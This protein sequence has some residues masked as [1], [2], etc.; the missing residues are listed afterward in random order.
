MALY[1]YIVCNIC[2]VVRDLLNKKSAAR[3]DFR[4]DVTGQDLRDV[5]NSLLWKTIKSTDPTSDLWPGLFGY[6]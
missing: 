1:L 3:I 4:L 2:C 5:K 6:Y